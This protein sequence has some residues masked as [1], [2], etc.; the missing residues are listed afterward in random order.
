MRPFKTVNSKESNKNGG[1]VKR[2]YQDAPKE[3]I[4]NELVKFSCRFSTKFSTVKSSTPKPAIYS[5]EAQVV[6]NTVLCSIL[7]SS[8]EEKLKREET[9]DL[10][11]ITKLEKLLRKHEVANLNGYH[12]S[13]SGLPSFFGSTLTA[14]YKSGEEIHFYDNQT[15][16]LKQDF[17]KELCIL[18]G[19]ED[20]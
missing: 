19:L 8:R 15:C 11:F 16:I 9:R 18:F 5:L 6:E 12:H 20:K 4:S 3:I 7:V 10:A 1:V 14:S 17:T 13:V 2:F